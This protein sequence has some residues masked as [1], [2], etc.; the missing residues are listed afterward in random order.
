ML[1]GNNNDVCALVSFQWVIYKI[2]KQ[3]H[4][5]GNK[6]NLLQFVKIVSSIYSKSL[7]YTATDEKQQSLW[8]FFSEKS[9]QNSELYKTQSPF[10]K[11]NLLLRKVLHLS[12]TW[13]FH[14][15]P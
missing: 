15:F 8:Q 4:V 2:E 3:E 6:L 12:R 5:H 13:N 14:M 10:S 1:N 9:S 11:N 7:F